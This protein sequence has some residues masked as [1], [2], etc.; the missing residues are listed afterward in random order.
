MTKTQF[1][2]LIVGAG[3]VGLSIAWQLHR[4]GQQ[5]ILVLEKGLK[6][7]EDR[8]RNVALFKFAALSRIDKHGIARLRRVGCPLA[9]QGTMIFASGGATVMTEL[10]FPG[11]PFSRLSVWADAPGVRLAGGRMHPL[12]S[13]WEGVAA[14]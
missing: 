2:V 9:A 4:R 8:V 5:R 13:I 12:R 14:P 7:D 10:V 6:R 11:E 1:D 3:I